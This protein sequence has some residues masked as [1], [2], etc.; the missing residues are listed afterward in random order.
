MRSEAKKMM[1]YCTYCPKMCRFS[2]PVSEASRT[3]TFTPW[4]KMEQAGWVIDKAISLSPEIAVSAYQCTNCLHCQQYCEHDNDVPTAL[5]VVRRVAVENYAAPDA[6]YALQERFA[7][8]NNPYGID[9]IEPIKAAFPRIFS[10]KKKETAFL[11]SCHTLR[12]FPERVK[13]Y[14][15][16]FEK[17]GLSGIQILE[18]PVQCCG[19]P[20]HALGLQQDFAEVGEVQAQALRQ[21]KTILT[22]GPECAYTLKETYREEG[23]PLKS[24][25]WNLME[26]LGPYLQHHNYRT[27]GKVKGRFAY[28]DPVFLARF[29]DL[30]RLPREI[31]EQL[32]GF[33]PIELSFHDKDTLSSGGEGGYDWIFPELSERIARRTTE[34]V[35]GRGVGILVTA[36][37][38]SEERFK[39]VAEGVEILDL[40]EFMNQHILK[41]P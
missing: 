33:Q 39:R 40:Y 20:L 14:F 13:T 32:T 29:L 5:R 2:C 6:V 34:E 37:A 19:A 26:F 25:V 21:Y 41:R 18:S 36:C 4:G 1:D 15:D 38:K 23:F 30:T 31:L 17:L 3:E 9:L 35:A 8:H 16:L 7:E 28:H 24:R 11:V 10:K 22:D 12:F 27:R